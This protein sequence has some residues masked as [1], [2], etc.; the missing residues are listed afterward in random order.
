MRS[1]KYGPSP[2]EKTRFDLLYEGYDALNEDRLNGG[3]F[4]QAIHT[5]FHTDT[6]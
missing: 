3:I 6:R 5:K 4:F 1:K 2:L